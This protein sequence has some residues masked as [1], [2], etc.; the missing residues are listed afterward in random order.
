MTL[1]KAPWFLNQMWVYIINAG[2]ILV[3]S[4]LK[5]QLISILWHLHRS[6][7]RNINHLKLNFV[8]NLKGRRYL[9]LIARKKYEMLFLSSICSFAVDSKGGRFNVKI[10]ILKGG[11]SISSLSRLTR[12]GAKLNLWKTWVQEKN[13]FSVQYLQE[14]K[15]I[16][17]KA[18]WALFWSIVCMKFYHFTIGRRDIEFVVILTYDALSSFY[19]FLLLK[20][21]VNDDAF[22]GLNR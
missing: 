6:S 2:C 11:I 12:I 21:P 15:H 20:C 22:P 17:Q 3:L 9:C 1:Q 13:Y 10:F 14:F 4:E 19:G 16:S 8:Q 18:V 5:I 7:L